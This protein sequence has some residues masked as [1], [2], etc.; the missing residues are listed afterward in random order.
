MYINTKEISKKSE[1]YKS[2]MESLNEEHK[3][4]KKIVTELKQGWQGERATKF[5]DSIENQYLIKFKDAIDS[6]NKYYT[7]L[8]KIPSAYEKLDD[9]YSRKK[10]N[11][12]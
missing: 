9:S 11:V 1:T 8:S 2:I 7:Y 4:L 10:I 12:K 3:N 6:L 5:F